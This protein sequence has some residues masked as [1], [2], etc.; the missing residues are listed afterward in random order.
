[1]C[2]VPAASLDVPAAVASDPTVTCPLIRCGPVDDEVA[3]SRSAGADRP[4]LVGH[5]ATNRSEFHASHKQPQ[6]QASGRVCTAAVSAVHTDAGHGHG[7]CTPGQVRT[8]LSPP[9]G[10]L[11]T[12]CRHSLLG[13]ARVSDVS[14]AEEASVFPTPRTQ[15]PAFACSLVC[16][17]GP[18]FKIL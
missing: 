13:A 1:M 9:S 4:S 10:A 17:C 14:S 15:S 2:D 18:N 5:A 3:V 7:A 12:H 6:T 8:N 11:C 16:S